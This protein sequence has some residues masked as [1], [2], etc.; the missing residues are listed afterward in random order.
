MQGLQEKTMLHIV[1]LFLVIRSADCKVHSYHRKP[2]IYKNKNVS[3]H[4]YCFL[5]TE[6]FNTETNNV[7]CKQEKFMMRLLV[8]KNVFQIHHNTRPLKLLSTQKTV[9][10]QPDRRTN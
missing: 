4:D 9:T 10:T 6:D 1:F 8:H 2:V 7:P 3:H 5:Q